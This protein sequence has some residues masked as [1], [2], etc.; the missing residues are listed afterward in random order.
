[1]GLNILIVDDSVTVRA[2]I[3]KTLKI[4]G[5]DIAE[6]FEAENGREALDIISENWVDLILADINMPIM[7]GVEMIERMQA[8]D[9]L[10]T[11]PVIIV[12]TEGSKT[13]IEELKDKGVKAYLRKPFTPE[14]ILD[15]VN[16]IVGANNVS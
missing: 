3:G 5:L 7:G 6:A 1:M 16:D 4:A 11:I 13:R 2:V 8:D 9:L 10:S 15:L 12:S 14:G